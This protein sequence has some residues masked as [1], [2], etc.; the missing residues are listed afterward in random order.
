M[1]TL[2]LPLAAVYCV[3]AWRGRWK[4]LAVGLPFPL[5]NL[6]IWAL[7][8]GTFPRITAVLLPFMLL[9]VAYLIEDLLRAL[10]PRAG[11]QLLWIL[12]ALALLLLPVASALRFVWLTAQTDTRTL[13][14]AWIAE[15]PGRG[16]GYPAELPTHDFAANR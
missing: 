1:L 3:V 2:L 15:K 16:R 5:L 9:A 14:Q 8:Q 7:F 12:A 13:A 10:L 11:R 6:A 4:L